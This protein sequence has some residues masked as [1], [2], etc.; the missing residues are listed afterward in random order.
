MP[1]ADLFRARGMLLLV[2]QSVEA[3]E[4]S[5]AERDPEAALDDL[6]AARLLLTAVVHALRRAVPQG[7]DD[8]RP[9]D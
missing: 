8:D 1:D 6:L 7:I 2:S 9:E 4:V 5:L 3:A